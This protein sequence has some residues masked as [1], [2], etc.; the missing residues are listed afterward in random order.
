MHILNE[1][2]YP[3]ALINFLRASIQKPHPDLLRV[4]DLHDA[5][6]IKHLMIKHWDDLVIDP[7]KHIPALLGTAWHAAMEA[8]RDATHITE[9]RLY[10][11]IDGITITG[12]PDIVTETTIEDFKTAS[13][14]QYIKQDFAHWTAQ[15]NSYLWL[16]QNLKNKRLIC[17]PLYKDWS[18]MEALRIKPYPP[19]RITKIMLT[20]WD[21]EHTEQ[22]IKQRVAIHQQPPCECTREEK[23]QTDEQWALKSTKRKTA[24]RV[25]DTKE[26]LGKYALAKGLDLTRPEYSIE[27]RPGLCKR[28]QDWC[29]V[30]TFC[31]YYK[32]QPQE[33]A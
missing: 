32:P 30:N 1:K 33:T 14:Y 28:C 8:N 25:L 2:L 13:V 20:Q 22:I 31:Q 12:Q 27:R 18:A 5:P 15:L 24:I 17:W 9:T 7:N 29:P 6:L 10:R 3:K 19:R 23:W 16:N 11:N 4:S 26:E 21:P